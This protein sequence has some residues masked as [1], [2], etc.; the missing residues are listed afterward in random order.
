MKWRKVWVLVIV[1]VI[2]AGTTWWADQ[3][4]VGLKQRTYRDKEEDYKSTDKA[5]TPHWKSYVWQ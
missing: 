1:L 4:S 3:T 5:D 2:G